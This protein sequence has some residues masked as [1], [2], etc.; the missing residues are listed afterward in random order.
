[1]TVEWDGAMMDV[2][3]LDTLGPNPFKG[4]AIS[5]VKITTGAPAATVGV[6]AKG[7]QVYNVFDGVWYQM[8]GTTAAPAWT[9]N[10]AVAGSPGGPPTAVQTNNSGVFGGNANFTYDLATDA[11]ASGLFDG[12]GG[13]Q[14]GWSHAGQFAF[15]KGGTATDFGQVYA[16]N[17][18]VQLLGSGV[19]EVYFNGG[20]H[21]I[22]NQAAA[23]TI[24]VTT[25]NGISAAAIST[26]SS[27]IAGVI[28]TTGTNNAGGNSVLHITF[29]KVFPTGWIPRVVITP[30]NSA[31]AKASDASLITPVVN[32]VTEAGFDV[33][34]TS[35]ASA[36]PTPSW[37]YH[38]IGAHN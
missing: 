4:L 1:M 34:M 32:N 25:A 26:H 24:S 10:S 21:I 20:S 30:L 11:F 35:D 17:F 5:G 36:L 33:V 13:G 6:W 15:I 12:A 31:A 28:T 19:G 22:S 14:A 7:A 18:G 38:V 27:D 29:S 16:N 3:F 23:P 8:S 2:G 37:S 9:I